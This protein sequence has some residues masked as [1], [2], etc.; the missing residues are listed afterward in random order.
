MESLELELAGDGNLTVT[1]FLEPLGDR[2]VE[3]APL[4]QRNVA[5][6]AQNQHQRDES[7]QHWHGTGIQPMVALYFQVKPVWPEGWGST[8]IEDGA[9]S[10][11]IETS[12]SYL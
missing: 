5:V 3:N 2:K 10:L 1:A 11:N 8:G 12:F 7:T 4:V 6:A 9:S